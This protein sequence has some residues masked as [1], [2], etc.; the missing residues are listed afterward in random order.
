MG[1]LI[2]A[3]SK[4]EAYQGILPQVNLCHT[5]AAKDVQIWEA[6]RWCGNWVHRYGNHVTNNLVWG[7][8]LILGDTFPP[9]A[10]V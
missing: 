1:R 5:L 9:G 8:Q 7:S 10:K 6:K 4:P 2:A 3:A